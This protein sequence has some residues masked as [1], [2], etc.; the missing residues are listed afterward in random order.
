MTALKVKYGLDFGTSLAVALIA[1]ALLGSFAGYICHRFRINPLVV[2][3]AMGTIAIGLVKVQIGEQTSGYPPQ[4]LINLAEPVT[5]T[6]GVGIPPSVAIW[7]LVVILFA[8]FLHRTAWG[9]TCSPRVRTRAP[10][11]ER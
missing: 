5:K 10:P 9:A 6:F 2:T 1:A 11:T 3:L 7:G 4:W 8:I